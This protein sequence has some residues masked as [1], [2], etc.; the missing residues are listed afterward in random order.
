MAKQIQSRPRFTVTSKSSKTC[1]QNY[2]LNRPKQ[3]RR[4]LNDLALP[5]NFSPEYLEFKNFNRDA[6]LITDPSTLLKF[7]I[8][9]EQLYGDSER[10]CKVHDNTDPYIY[11]YI[12]KE[13]QS[14][15][16]VESKVK[17]SYLMAGGPPVH[18]ATLTVY[19]T[20]NKVHVQGSAENV[21]KYIDH[22]LTRMMEITCSSQQCDMQKINCLQ[23]CSDPPHP[24]PLGISSDN[25]TVS[26]SP[27]C[28]VTSG[29][30]CEVQL[31]ES[32]Q[33]FT[34]FTLPPHEYMHHLVS[35][36][37]F[38]P[39]VVQ[40]EVL[41][42][43]PPVS[44]TVNSLI[45]PQHWTSGDFAG[46]HTSIDEQTVFA[47]ADL[48]IPE[49][50]ITTPIKVNSPSGKSDITITSITPSNK[51]ATPSS[52][53][54]PNSTTPSPSSR[55]SPNATTPSLTKTAEKQ[56][57][58]RLSARL[59]KL[60]EAAVHANVAKNELVNNWHQASLEMSELRKLVAD[61]LKEN[62]AVRAQHASTCKENTKLKDSL[63]ELG[64]QVKYLHDENNKLRSSIGD[65]QT[66]LMDRAS[67]LELQ[68][69]NLHIENYRLRYRLEATEGETLRLQHAYIA[70][71]HQL[72]VFGGLSQDITSLHSRVSMM[73]GAIKPPLA[74]FVSTTSPTPQPVPNIIKKPP[75]HSNSYGSAD[76][77]A[78]ATQN[79]QTLRNT[80]S[81]QQPKEKLKNYILGDSNLHGIM[82]IVQ[83][84]TNELV[85]LGTS[86]ANFATLHD[87]VSRLPKC[88]LL[89]LQGGT[90]DANQRNHPTDSIPDLLKLITA[91]K[92]KAQKV[93]L[94]PPPP[95]FHD[96]KVMGDIM[97][98]EAQRLGV[99]SIPVNNLF[100][101]SGPFVF[102]RN[103]L[104]CT[105]LGSGIYGLAV[106][107]YL[108][109]RTQLISDK[110]VYSCIAC[111]RTGHV[112]SFCRRYPQRPE[113]QQRSS[114]KTTHQVNRE[115]QPHQST[116]QPPPPLY[117]PR[118]NAQMQPQP[119]QPLQTTPVPN[120]SHQPDRMTG[121]GGNIS[122][123]VSTSNRYAILVTE[124]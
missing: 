122:Y 50:P 110:S 120:Q 72:G 53:Y 56:H 75:M 80:F 4:K 70:M 89:M 36:T 33:L 85:F 52:R 30:L 87:Q 74:S 44:E 15:A 54:S 55:Y 121:T 90:N 83:N 7:N 21:K 31:P 101:T 102:T 51:Q 25:L 103:K 5:S 9:I 69:H 114:N 79:P 26:L 81:N 118:Q 1:R 95:S 8:L 82:P 60:E 40:Q 34:S 17:T 2:L 78:S 45:H 88:N 39:Q 96:A 18:L 58:F 19:N 84:Q 38:S 98:A 42:I 63:T 66:K 86:G 91:A 59:A 112:Y 107:N 13:D 116:E 6:M 106:I 73:E 64:G 62:Q 3:E 99:D 11:E 111:H 43:E 32:P 109:D 47:E 92:Y 94:I 57:I 68:V 119:R 71:Q 76:S 61:V 100:P 14:G 27:R 123:R 48:S 46:D 28:D 35:E 24:S 124:V 97:C 65:E 29:L 113:R 105:R 10:A 41:A 93:V 49:S 67:S 23:C 22:F 77:I 108:K 104:H 117:K 16:F 37:P 20:A 115:H 12:V